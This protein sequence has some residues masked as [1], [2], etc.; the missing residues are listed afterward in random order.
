[1]YWV[2]G[3]LRYQCTCKVGFSGSNCEFNRCSNNLHAFSLGA[4]L[5]NSDYHLR[6]YSLNFNASNIDQ[7]KS[8][9]Y[10]LKTLL[11]TSVDI[12]GDGNITVAEMVTALK[13]RS[14]WSAGAS[15]LFLW[16]R[17]ASE[18][19]PYCYQDL[20]PTMIETYTIYK[21]CMTNF[22]TSP[23]HTF[24]GSGI[25]VVTSLS[26]TYPSASWSETQCK[27]YNSRW[28][29]Q[30]YQ[31]VTTSW[32]W[33]G[34]NALDSISRVC[35][36]ENGVFNSEFVK[37]IVLS[38]SQTNFMDYTNVSSSN[39]FKRVYCISVDRGQTTSYECSVGLFYVSL[40]SFTV[41]VLTKFD[42]YILSGWHSS[43]SSTKPDLRRRSVFIS[44]HLYL[45]IRGTM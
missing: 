8:V 17:S 9:S 34:S 15:N 14:V 42:I 6:Q 41:I 13:Y 7:M 26:S 21:D 33:T 3:P 31:H 38:G 16:C 4:L 22:L 18:S 45:R 5:F 25:P 29:P 11:V 1:M 20:N 10:Y 35:G 39:L 30:T 43:R 40:T 32:S 27:A 28:F 2:G 36:Y 24:D 12:N 37:S 23:K 44:G 19:P